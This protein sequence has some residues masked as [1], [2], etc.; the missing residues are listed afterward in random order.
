MQKKSENVND[1]MD[2]MHARSRLMEELKDKKVQIRESAN[3]KALH[4]AKQLS[5]TKKVI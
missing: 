3:K 4:N 1:I 5:L 2:K